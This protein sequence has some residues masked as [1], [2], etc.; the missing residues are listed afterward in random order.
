MKV[1]APW[2]DLSPDDYLGKALRQLESIDAARLRADHP[3]VFLLA[4]V[5]AHIIDHLKQKE[6]T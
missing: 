4:L 6:R 1:Y 2:E 3:D 5:V